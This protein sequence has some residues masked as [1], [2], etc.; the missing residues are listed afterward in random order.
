MTLS[1]RSARVSCLPVPPLRWG[2]FSGFADRRL[3][4]RFLT[5]KIKNKL[6]YWARRRYF[7]S[8]DRMHKA[9]TGR[10]DFSLFTLFHLIEWTKDR[11]V[12]IGSFIVFY[13][14]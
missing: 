10:I 8:I 9:Q 14:I 4:K 1:E 7:V 12:C 13:T 5:M 6:V 3:E 2:F 11:I